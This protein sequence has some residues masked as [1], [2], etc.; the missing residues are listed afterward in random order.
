[1]IWLFVEGHPQVALHAMI[2]TKLYVARNAVIGLTALPL[3]AFSTDNFYNGV[4]IDFV[5]TF[6]CFVVEITG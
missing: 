4:T 6:F 5:M 2:F 1:M 3:K